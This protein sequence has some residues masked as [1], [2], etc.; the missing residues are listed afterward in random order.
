[1]PPVAQAD[2]ASA[3]PVDPVRRVV[4][5]ADPPL[6]VAK[7]ASGI[8][9]GARARAT[10]RSHHVGDLA[11]ARIRLYPYGKR[12]ALSRAPR[13]ADEAVESFPING[14]VVLHCH[15]ANDG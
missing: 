13:A 12:H 15:I 1:M 8:G 7:R 2:V 4:G 11:N 5:F 9:C 3:R 14:F 10:N 6:N